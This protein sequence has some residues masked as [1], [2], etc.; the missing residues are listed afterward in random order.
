DDKEYT[1]TKMY[2]VKDAGKWTTSVKKDHVVFTHILKGTDGYAYEYQ[3]TVRLAEGLP[4]LILEHRLKNTGQKPIGTS[5]Y[6]HNFLVID[7][8][9]TGPFIRTSF[10]KEIT[11]EGRN[12]GEIIFP[13]GNRLTYERNLQKGENVY[14]ANVTAADNSIL[15][16]D[17]KIDN[18]KTGAGVRISGDRP[19][20]KMVFWACSTTSCPE[21]YIRLSVSPGEEI[22]W[23]IAYEFYV[24]K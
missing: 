14:T 24:N 20:E 4:K 6:N 10:V 9:P 23:N 15:P 18:T 19:L 21:P 13:R 12:F 22:S 8:E 5:T 7:Q 16:Y 2:A 3:K 1:F 17:I 11:A